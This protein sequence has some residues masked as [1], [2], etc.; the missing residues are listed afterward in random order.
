MYR[1]H[2]CVRICVR[3]CETVEVYHRYSV[4]I[5]DDEYILPWNIDN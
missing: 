3:V 2:V 1:V 5:L 4:L